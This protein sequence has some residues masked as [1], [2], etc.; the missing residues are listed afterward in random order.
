VTTP[1]GPARVIGH[2]ILARQLLVE[3]DDRRRKLIDVAA[4]T[5]FPAEQAHDSPASSD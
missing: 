1:D 3:T 2:E 4:A 5:P